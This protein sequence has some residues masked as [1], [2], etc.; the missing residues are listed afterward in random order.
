MLPELLNGLINVF[1]PMTFLLMVFGTIVGVVIGALPGLSG[2]T[3]II[4]LLPLVYQL[5]A[6]T[7]IVMLCGLFCGSMY[8]GSI[9]AV[10]LNTPGTPSAAATML[11]GYPLCQQGLAGKALG[12]SAT[13]SFLGGLISSICLIL[14]APQLAKIALS[15]HAADYFALSLFGLTIMASTDKNIVKGLISGVF[16]LLIST[17]GIDAVAGLDRFTFGI[18]RLYLGL[19]LAVCLIGL[20][21]LVEILAKWDGVNLG[22]YA[23]LLTGEKGNLSQLNTN[24]TALEPLSEYSS[25]SSPELVDLSPASLP[26]M[27][28]RSS[29]STLRSSA[30]V[31]WRE[32][33]LLRHR[34]TERQAALSSRC[35]R[36]AF[37][38]MS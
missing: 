13:S 10:L 18:P 27:S 12:V 4:L 5:D 3:G 36:S 25:E 31:R 26:T 29:R 21:A 28:R 23:I 20:F 2:S 22:A 35:S 32:L 30:M 24:A 17:V 15:F 34:T 16:G 33:R 8:G 38:G 19:D 6:A 37:R 14:I 11:D 7:A 9:A 1:H